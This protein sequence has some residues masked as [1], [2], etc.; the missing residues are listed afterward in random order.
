MRLEEAAVTTFEAW[1]QQHEQEECGAIDLHFAE[2]RG[3]VPR[4][5]LVLD[6][7]WAAA[8]NRPMPETVSPLAMLGAIAMIEDYWKPMA[9][10]IYR[11]GWTPGVSP[12]TRTL[13][14]WI[15]V[16]RRTRINRR[17]IYKNARLPGL[18]KPEAVQEALD[19]LTDFG[20]VRHA[21]V[22]TGTGRRPEDYTVTP[23]IYDLPEAV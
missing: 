9:L 10:K 6:H 8:E 16:G 2:M 22:R 13:A 4:L 23:A 17:D 1:V 15:L 11:V 19:D 18:S 7:L 12:Q 5:A 14:R 3:I 21:P 20:W